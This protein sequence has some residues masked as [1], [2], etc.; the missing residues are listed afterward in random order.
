MDRE[1]KFTVD[2]SKLLL[3]SELQEYESYLM[4]LR[5][6]TEKDYKNTLPEAI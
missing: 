1:E 4:R 2:T 3:L 6:Y 5:L